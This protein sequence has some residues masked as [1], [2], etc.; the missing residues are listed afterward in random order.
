M[1]EGITVIDNSPPTQFTYGDYVALDGKKAT[2]LECRAVL[3]TMK[4]FLRKFEDNT[5]ILDCRLVINTSEKIDGKYTLGWRVTTDREIKST[6]L[7]GKK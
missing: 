2:N 3:A 6:F 7:V 4:A 1:S 5:N